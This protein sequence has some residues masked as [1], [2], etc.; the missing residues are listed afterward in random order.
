MAGGKPCFP[1]LW[2]FAVALNLNLNN[3]VNCNVNY[4]QKQDVE[5]V[6]NDDFCR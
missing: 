1:I 4:K 2:Y 6:N 3:K 5:F